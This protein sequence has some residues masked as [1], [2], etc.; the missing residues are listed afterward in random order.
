MKPGLQDAQLNTLLALPNGA[1]TTTSAG[2]DLQNSPNGDFTGHVQF[3]LVVPAVTTSML[4][5]AGTITYDIYTSP[6]ADLSSSTKIIAGLI[7]QTG[8]S[9]A[10][11]AG[12]SADF[13][14]PT[15]VA[16]YLFYKSVKSG[17]GNASTV[18]AVLSPRV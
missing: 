8:A 9:S 12:A 15:S 17:T 6:N 13:R 14:V 10:G 3:T 18:N 4:P 1:A 7:V 2:I 16:R 11:A 5:D